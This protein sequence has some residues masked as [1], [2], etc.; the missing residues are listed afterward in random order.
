MRARA[1]EVVTTGSP[2]PMTVDSPN[3]PG[4][5]ES[6]AFAFRPPSTTTFSMGQ[7]NKTSSGS[8]KKSAS[9]RARA[10]AMVA[11]N[12]Q[13]AETTSNVASSPPMAPPAQTVY[14]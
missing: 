8:M 13:A 4:R 11:E 10:R 6:E 14:V 12:A 2:E 5:R 7:S 1:S 3:D 9:F